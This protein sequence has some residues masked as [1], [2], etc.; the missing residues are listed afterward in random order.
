MRKPCRQSRIG[1]D[2]KNRSRRGVVAQGRIACCVLIREI[3]RVVLIDEKQFYIETRAQSRCLL[4][5]S[6]GTNPPPRR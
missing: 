6:T 3:R 1:E 4:G 2:Q 5:S